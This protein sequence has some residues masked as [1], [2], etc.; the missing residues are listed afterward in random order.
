MAKVSVDRIRKTMFMATA[1]SYELGGSEKLETTPG[2]G[3][4]AGPLSKVC[5]RSG[6]G[7][8]IADMRNTRV[9]RFDLEDEQMLLP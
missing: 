3:A 5:N 6:V 2:G 7:L 4:K 9:W 8:D 1:A